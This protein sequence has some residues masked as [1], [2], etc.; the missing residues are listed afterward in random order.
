MPLIRGKTTRQKLQDKGLWEEY[1]KTFPYKP[2]AKFVQTG[3]EPMT[4]DADVS[5]D[6]RSILY[7]QT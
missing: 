7:N 6:Q 2:L 3:T 4:N 1:R 5:T